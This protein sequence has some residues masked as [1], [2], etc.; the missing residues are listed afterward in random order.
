MEKKKLKIAIDIHGVIDSLPELFSLITELMVGANHEVHVLTGSKWNKEIE[1]QLES[2]GIKY[3]HHFSITDYHLS[4]GTKMR[5]STPNDPWIETGDK[6][7]DEILWDRTKGDYCEKHKIDLCI[8][9]TLRYNDYFKN[10]TAF[11]R[12]WTH[13]NTPKPKHKD[14]RHLD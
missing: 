7:Q 13:T 9:D 14:K 6:K 5:Y 8:D 1:D 10:G 3:T 12:L 11:A 4:I 2:F